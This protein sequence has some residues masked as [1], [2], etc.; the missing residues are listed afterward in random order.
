M[1]SSSLSTMTLQFIILRHIEQKNISHHEILILMGYH[2]HPKTQD[3]ALKRL[4][5]VLSSPALG[6]TNKTYDFKYA[7]S[8]FAEK[9]CMVLSIDTAVYQPLLTDLEHDASHLLNAIT[10][11]VYADI[12]F[13]EH[14]RP[15]F[16]SYMA[17]DRFKR[18]SLDSK[19]KLFTRQ[20]QLDIINER[21]TAHHKIMQ[22][23]IPFAEVI[24][25]YRVVFNN[26]CDDEELRYIAA[27]YIEQDP[28]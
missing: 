5:T 27:K 8:K 21:I 4:Q 2:N 9:L 22:G 14:F 25:G 15:S 18:I 20:K 13:N 16:N 17:V 1:P 26:G 10:P 3:K 28:L 19:V 7:S 24:K 6:F 23:K 11:I 12:T